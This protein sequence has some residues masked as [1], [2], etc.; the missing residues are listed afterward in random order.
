M[1]ESKS[2]KKIKYIEVTKVKEEKNSMLV[3]YMLDG[4]LH[5]MTVPS[6]ILNR[7]EKKGQFKVDQKLLEAG[8]E[9]GDSLISAFED[10]VIDKETLVDVFHNHGI[11]KFED[12]LD[13]P[14]LIKSAVNSQVGGYVAD[15]QS[16]FYKQIN[17]GK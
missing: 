5:R 11:W 13:N 10:I 4:V 15:I 16:K 7:G 17:G 1:S 8:I 14:S 3:Q 2:K 12:I 6:K 9:Y